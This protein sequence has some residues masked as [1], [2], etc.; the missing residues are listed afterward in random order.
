[1][2]C[3]KKRCIAIVDDEENIRTTLDIALRKEGY[4]TLLF[5]DGM[6]AL[7]Q[8]QENL[9]DLFILDILMPRLDGLELCKKVRKITE[10]VPIIFLSSKDDE[11]DRVLG[12]ELG[13]DDYLCKPFSMRELT[14]RI[15]VLFR[16]I[17]KLSV[18]DPEPPEALI[19]CGP[20]VLDIPKHRVSLNGT[21]V[22]VTVTE[23][24]ILQTLAVR[25]GF[26]KTRGDLVSV[27]FPYDS[28]VNPRVIDSH[29]KRLR[30]KLNECAP[31]YDEIETVHG[32]GYRYKSHTV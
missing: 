29:M 22:P 24:R 15:K 32:L 6:E 23:F 2:S 27:C 17:S 1:M 20:L 30:R 11:L 31:G 14:T 21:A 16:R 13:A 12:L 28:Y 25:P 19:R 5:K 26:V 3:E 8:V 18:E 10:H 7:K 4:D 9:P